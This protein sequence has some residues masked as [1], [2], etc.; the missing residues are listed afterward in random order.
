V[1]EK[2]GEVGLKWKV[3]KRGEWALKGG[4]GGVETA[5]ASGSGAG[6]CSN[7]GGGGGGS[8]WQLFSHGKIA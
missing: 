6:R 5:L 4:G 1:L 7:R 3:L 8:E 2:R